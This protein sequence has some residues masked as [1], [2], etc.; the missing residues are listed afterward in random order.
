[1]LKPYA[2]KLFKEIITLFSIQCIKI[3]IIALI[4]IQRRNSGLL[5]RRRSSDSQKIMDLLRSLDYL[6]RPDEIAESPPGY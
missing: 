5:K 3:L 4:E 2:V 1:M 6:L